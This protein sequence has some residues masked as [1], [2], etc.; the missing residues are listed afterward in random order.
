MSSGFGIRRTNPYTKYLYEKSKKPEDKKEDEEE[1]K[2]ET[3][4]P[5]PPV[6][7]KGMS[8]NPIPSAKSDFF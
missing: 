8:M 2:K 1:D 3:E 6:K 7:R 4:T 5:S